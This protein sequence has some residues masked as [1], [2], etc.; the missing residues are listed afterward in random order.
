MKKSI[1]ILSVGILLVGLFSFTTMDFFSSM[2]KVDYID[3][4]KTLKF[5][6]KLNTS[7]ISQ[8]V[9]IDPATAA[10]EAEVKKY[11]NNNVDVSINGA[12]KA[13]TFTGSQVNGESVW[14]YYEASG[15][16]DISSLKIKNSILVGQFPKQVNIVNIT[17]KGALKTLNFQ[18]GK[19]TAEVSF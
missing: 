9:K 13:L 3:G 2:T 17:Y 18:K 19:E 16:S 6:T 14:V 1:L 12:P 7:H 15:I 10:F 11:V 4:T 5:T 8:A